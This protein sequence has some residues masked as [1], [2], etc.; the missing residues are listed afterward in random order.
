VTEAA[1]GREA[2]ARLAEQQ[3]DLLLLDVH[4]PIMDGPE[5]IRHIRAATASWHDI[6]VVA[7]TADTMTG[8]KERLLPIGMTGYVPKP[9]EQRAL[10]QEIHRVLSISEIAQAN[11]SESSP[12]AKPPQFVHRA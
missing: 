1:N 5:T 3:F 8:D 12:R 4:M 6:P 11:E 9:I 2:L 7:L 10:V